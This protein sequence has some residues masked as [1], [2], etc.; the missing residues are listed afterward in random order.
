VKGVKAIRAIDA[1]LVGL[2]APA[3]WDFSATLSRHY[4][5]FMLAVRRDERGRW[6]Y[7][8]SRSGILRA[9]DKGYPS[10]EAAMNAAEIRTR[11]LR[12]ERGKP[13]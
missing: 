1:A 2:T 4:R 6:A 13:W 3:G 7:L 12:A 9:T 8:V 5:E 11:L 10:A